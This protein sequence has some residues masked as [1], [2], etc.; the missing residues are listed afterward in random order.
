VWQ[1]GACGA[2]ASPARFSR[3]TL[4]RG[5]CGTLPAEKS[6]RPT[7]PCDGPRMN[8]QVD[9]GNPPRPF[10]HL[11]MT[12][13]RTPD[14]SSSRVPVHSALVQKSVTAITNLAG[15]LSLWML[16]K[17]RWL[18]KR[19]PRKRW[20]T[21]CYQ[22]N[23]AGE[24]RLASY[25]REQFE[26]RTE[27]PLRKRNPSVTGYAIPSGYRLIQLQN[28]SIAFNPLCDFP[29]ALHPALLPIDAPASRIR[30]VRRPAF[31]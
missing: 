16:G 10:R 6:S 18:R 31:S 20:Q 11:R 22:S 3:K 12:E 25:C 26:G 23:E 9:V 19:K 2:G 5:S 29:A 24:L 21:A 28:H 14:P 30:L 1:L 4:P 7:K 27:C 8:R 17:V 15:R 13:R